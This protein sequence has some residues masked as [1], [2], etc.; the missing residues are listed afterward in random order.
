LKLLFCPLFSGSGGN[1][2]LVA[3]QRTRLLIDAGMSALAIGRALDNLS[4]SLRDIDGVLIT[5]E[6][7]DHVKGIATLAKRYGIPVYANEKTWLAMSG[8]A[9]EVPGPLLRV[10]ETGSDFYVSDIAVRSF[11]TPHD[12]AESV[13]FTLCAKGSTACLMTDIGHVTKELIVRAMEADVVLIES[14]HDE[15]LLKSGPYPAYLKRRILSGTGHLSNAD[16]GLAVTKLAH[17]GVKRF[18]LGHLSVQNN[19]E[20]IAISAVCGALSACG[21]VPGRD[22]ALI[23]AKKDAISPISVFD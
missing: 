4:V 8:I 6:H 15:G 23:V 7:T 20:D 14:N 11:A 21:I 17:G 10:F 3:T 16:A 18:Y 5:H 12:A 22:V 19:R 1:A 9:A 2:T 13:G